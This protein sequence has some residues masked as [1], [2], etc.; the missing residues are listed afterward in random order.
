MPRVLVSGEWI[1]FGSGY[2]GIPAISLIDPLPAGGAAYLEAAP[3][4]RRS[5]VSWAGRELCGLPLDVCKADLRMSSRME[6]TNHH[7]VWVD[8]AVQLVVSR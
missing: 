7:A 5:K 1:Q 2:L 6:A 4:P 3:R 8:L